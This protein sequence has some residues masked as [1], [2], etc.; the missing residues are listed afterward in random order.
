MHLSGNS[1]QSNKY[2]AIITCTFSRLDCILNK[3]QIL[4]SFEVEMSHEDHKKIT[5]KF[6]SYPDLIETLKSHPLKS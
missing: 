2:M 5:D 4:S 1:Y 6:E 3:S